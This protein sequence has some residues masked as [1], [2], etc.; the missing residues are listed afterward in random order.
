MYGLFGHYCSVLGNMFEYTSLKLIDVSKYQEDLEKSLYEDFMQ[1]N[2]A[3]MLNIRH[4]DPETS[5]H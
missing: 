3:L 4:L 5:Y 2:V 1:C